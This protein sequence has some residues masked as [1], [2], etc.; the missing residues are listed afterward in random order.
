MPQVNTLPIKPIENID[1][2]GIQ[3]D[4]LSS[5]SESRRRFDHEFERQLAA[6]DSGKSNANRHDYQKKSNDVISTDKKNG[7]ASKP[8]ESEEVKEKKLSAN[9]DISEKSNDLSEGIDENLETEKDVSDNVKAEQT[10]QSSD[11]MADDKTE[12]A[13][14][15]SD[16]FLLFLSEVEKLIPQDNDTE[17]TL[18]KKGAAES[19]I[20]NSVELLNKPNTEREAKDKTNNSGTDILTDIAIKGAKAK[21]E[22]VSVDN[23]LNEEILNSNEKIRY[24]LNQIINDQSASAEQVK[25]AKSIIDNLLLKSESN[26][27]LAQIKEQLAKDSMAKNN[28]II[29]QLLLEQKDSEKAINSDVQVTSLEAIVAVEDDV[30]ILNQTK[31]VLNTAIQNKESQPKDLKNS[32]LNNVTNSLEKADVFKDKDI[33]KNPDLVA[34]DGRTASTLSP[35]EKIITDPAQVKNISTKSAVL[36]A[37]IASSDPKLSNSEAQVTN[38]DADILMAKEVE[39]LDSLIPKDKKVFSQTIQHSPTAR[40]DSH[41]A[42]TINQVADEGKRSEQS[43]DSLLNMIQSDS[44]IQTPKTLT[45]IQS[46]VAS[47][48]SKDF[49]GVVKEKV[50]VMIN[51]KIQ[52]VDIQ[53]DPPEMGS[54]QVRLNLQNEQAVVT[55]NVQNQQA[56]EALEQNMGRLKDML[57][58]TGVDVGDANVNQQ[59]N[60]QG[61]T[62]NSGEQSQKNSPH[63]EQPEELIPGAQQ[64]NVLKASST[65]IDYY[66]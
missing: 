64:L 10:N 59:S 32:S 19:D 47:V 41:A 28:P 44:S 58:Q 18:N 27:S 2:T 35:E 6:E 15:K 30:A 21:I 29:N 50:M 49:S 55:F 20:Q 3:K 56:K 4:L 13:V 23:Q 60:N 45:P 34:Q 54:M 12:S 51:Q 36:N 7:V 24:E 31:E 40:V 61:D 63:L 25:E 38:E 46:E 16:E 42:S 43:L 8:I 62:L 22:T 37:A 53:L 57:A 11:N 66:A 17:N 26:L 14:D 65:G 52:Q 5:D 9:D 33:A 39:V 48:Y 1:S